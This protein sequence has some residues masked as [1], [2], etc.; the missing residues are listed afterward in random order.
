MFTSSSA[1]GHMTMSLENL[2]F[3]PSYFALNSPQYFSRFRPGEIKQ[4]IFSAEELEVSAG[5]NAGD[6]FSFSDING[7]CAALTHL[8]QWQSLSALTLVE[9][10]GKVS[11]S[12]LATLMS[13]KKLTALEVFGSSSDC[14]SLAKM[15]HIKSLGFIHL[16][17]LNDYMSF[18]QNFE[19]APW[20]IAMHVDKGFFS[21]AEMQAILKSKLQSLELQS[22]KVSASTLSRLSAVKTISELTLPYKVLDEPAVVEALKIFPNLRTFHVAHVPR[23]QMYKLSGLRHRLPAVDITFMTLSPAQ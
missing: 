1:V 2:R 19:S 15:M 9:L 13:L 17:A 12:A 23:E 11:P 4:L 18:F 14:Q 10:T 5:N 20:L 3:S 8:P 16:V 7:C 6:D 21:D 22:E